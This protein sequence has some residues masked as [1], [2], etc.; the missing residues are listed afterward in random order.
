M[1]SHNVQHWVPT[2]PFAGRFQFRLRHFHLFR[3][4]DKRNTLTKIGCLS[5]CVHLY[6]HHQPLRWTSL[7]PECH[8]SYF[9]LLSYIFWQS[10]VV[11]CPSQA[12]LSVS[13]LQLADQ[14]CQSL[15]QHQAQLINCFCICGSVACVCLA[16]Y[17]FLRLHYYYC[18]V[19]CIVFCTYMWQTARKRW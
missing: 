5:C 14:I 6:Y 19:G 4:L 9:A 2:S 10:I 18:C 3:Q 12:L 8:S 13:Y 15:H 1:H 11:Q 17:Y 16:A 7:S